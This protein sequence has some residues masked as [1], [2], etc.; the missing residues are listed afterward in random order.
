MDHTSLTSINAEERSQRESSDPKRPVF[1]AYLEEGIPTRSRVEH[2]T[3]DRLRET[4]HSKAARSTK[5]LEREEEVMLT[6]Y[7]TNERLTNP[8]YSGHLSHTGIV[9]QG[10][11]INE[12]DVQVELALHVEDYIKIP[13]E[14]Y[15]KGAM[16]KVDDCFYNDKG[17]FLY[18]VPGLKNA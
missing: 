13:K 2:Y 4:L 9:S 14:Q 12:R 5:P 10:V 8:L 7:N 3:L 11:D 16:Y 1:D 17:E 18:R 6:S 15:T